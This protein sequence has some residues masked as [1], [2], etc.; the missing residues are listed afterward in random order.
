MSLPVQ[1]LRILQGDDGD[2]PELLVRYLFEITPEEQRRLTG[3]SARMLKTSEARSQK[4]GGRSQNEKPRGP[5]A[6][7]AEHRLSIER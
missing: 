6:A 3:M 4:S 1:R 2:Q 5:V 7:K